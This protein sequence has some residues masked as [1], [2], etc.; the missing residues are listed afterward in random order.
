MLASYTARNDL[1]PL[2]N[3]PEDVVHLIFENA[4]QLWPHWYQHHYIQLGSIRLVCRAWMQHVDASPQYWRHARLN[5][6]NELLE[7]VLHRSRG[8]PIIVD[9]DTLNPQPNKR[10]GSVLLQEL[11][12][13]QWPVRAFKLSYSADP[14]VK[15][16]KALLSEFLGFPAPLLQTLH[17]DLKKI[18]HVAAPTLFAGI[19]PKLKTLYLGNIVV[20][21]STIALPSL[22]SM[23]LTNVRGP[24]EH[25]LTV[26]ELLRVLRRCPALDSLTINTPLHDSEQA[27]T[28]ETLTLIHLKD[29][30]I[31]SMTASIARDLLRAIVAPTCEALK[32]TCN[33][34]GIADPQLFHHL[35]APAFNMLPMSDL[36]VDIRGDRWLSASGERWKVSLDG[37]QLRWD[38]T[39]A[40]A[41]RLFLYSMPPIARAAVSICK[42]N[43]LSANQRSVLLP[44]LHE[45]FPQL[46]ELSITLSAINETLELDA[47]CRPRDRLWQLGLHFRPDQRGW[48]LPNLQ[49]VVLESGEEKLWVAQLEAVVKVAKA[50]RGKVGVSRLKTFRASLKRGDRLREGGM[51][52]FKKMDGLFEAIDYGRES[53][54]TSRDAD[55][56]FSKPGPLEWFP[57]DP[58]DSVL[59]TIQ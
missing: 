15:S 27:P 39:A 50:R 22:V 30:S 46:R 4:L 48:L 33:E 21:W 5:I 43:R 36:T 26:D 41:R 58:R 18:G 7:I 32:V 10:N 23:T 37:G 9:C 59:I 34:E 16:Q 35:V 6:R 17:V 53:G 8:T 49:T 57:G 31:G 19:A 1:A 52:T 24:V 28:S 11:A 25:P 3:L 56:V 45:A 42:M 38:D 54:Y 29:V 14:I 13:L 44:V 12:R 20:H 2:N 47:L 55:V 40:E 51:K